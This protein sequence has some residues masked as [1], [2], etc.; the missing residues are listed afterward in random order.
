MRQQTNCENM[1]EKLPFW[2]DYRTLNFTHKKSK[3]HLDR[4][5][6]YVRAEFNFLRTVLTMITDV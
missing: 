1:V 5:I 4:K 3:L 2:F 6:E